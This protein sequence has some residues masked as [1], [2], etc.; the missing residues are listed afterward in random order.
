M[1][2]IKAATRELNPT[3][4][5]SVIDDAI[6]EDPVSARSE[7]GGE[8]RADISSFLSEEEITNATRAAG[9]IDQENIELVQ[10]GVFD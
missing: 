1:I 8:F 4:P 7:W 9:V 2:F 3:L 10:N 5:Q 6:A